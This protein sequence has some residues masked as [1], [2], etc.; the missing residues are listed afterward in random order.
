MHS[1]FPL[2]VIS[3]SKS[4]FKYW[5]TALNKYMKYLLHWEGHSKWYLSGFMHARI[6]YLEKQSLSRQEAIF[7]PNICYFYDFIA[8]LFPSFLHLQKIQMANLVTIM[9]WLQTKFYGICPLAYLRVLKCSLQ[10][11]QKHILRHRESLALSKIK[12]GVS[13]PLQQKSARHFHCQDC[14]LLNDL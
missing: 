1:N 9:V 11:E 8:K 5:Y 14:T 7:K 10:T 2:W 13:M 6:K 12:T 4:G 3:G